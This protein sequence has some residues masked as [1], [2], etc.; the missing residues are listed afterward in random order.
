MK[1]FLLKNRWLG[2]QLCRRHSPAARPIARLNNAGRF[3]IL[4]MLLVLGLVTGFEHGALKAV[5]SLHALATALTFTPLLGLTAVPANCQAVTNSLL[6]ESGRFGPGIFARAART[7]PII[8]LVN[9]TAGAWMNGMGL[10]IG[11]VTFERSLPDTLDGVWADMALSD[12]S[13]NNSCLPPADHVG[14]GATNRNYTPQHMAIN[15]DYFCIRDIQFDWQYEEMIRK[16]TQA[17]GDISQWVWASK[18]TRDYVNNSG[19]HLTLD[20]THG[21]QDDNT[22]WTGTAIQYNTTN[23]PTARLSQRVLDDIYSVLWREGADLASGIDTNTEEPVFD[24][25]LSTEQSRNVIH[26]DPTLAADNRYAFM[27]SKDD[28]NSPLRIGLPTKRRQYGGFFH[29]IDPYPR[30]FTLTGGVYVQVAPFVQSA[31]TKGNKWELNP[32][33]KAAPYEEVIVYHRNVYQ[34][35]SVNTITNPAPGWNFDARTWM[36]EFSPRNIL[37]RTCNPD[38]T[39][40][41]WRALFASAAKPLNPAVGYSILVKS[42]PQNLGLADCYNVYS[43]Y[44]F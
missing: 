17:F 34:N 14:F 32:A 37:D 24:V 38:G 43:T 30:K 23:P 27:G 31:T 18:F 42:C 40:I 13:S 35:L 21:E 2:R 22:T 36:G 8:G 16:I 28:P 29:T 20:T 26:S 4:A 7:R 33:Y 25:I 19:H 6:I 44:P 10:T 1:N 5:I 15:T 12:G 41:F 11:A 3:G 9:A 39:M